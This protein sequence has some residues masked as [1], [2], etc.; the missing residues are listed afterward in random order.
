[1][2]NNFEI[3]KCNVVLKDEYI[4]DINTLS[5]QTNI[6]KIL[7]IDIQ[8]NKE[9]LKSVSENDFK[10]Y[11]KRY[12]E[13]NEF[14][15]IKNIT[16]DEILPYR[17]SNTYVYAII[18]LL[19][20]VFEN[21]DIVKKLEES[22]FINKI[23]IAIGFLIVYFF[24]NLGYAFLYGFYFG[25][26]TIDKI[27]F[28]QM[29]VNPVPFNFKS[30]VGI[31]LG[32]FVY[33]ILIGLPLMKILKSDNTK[34]RIVNTVIFIGI[35]L[36][37]V[38]CSAFLFIGTLDMDVIF[39]DMIYF[40]ITFIMLPITILIMLLFVKY[41]QKYTFT[42]LYGV[43]YTIMSAFI[44]S[45]YFGSKLNDYAKL[46]ILYAMY[47]M[48]VI[49]AKI[50][51]FVL[52]KIEKIQKYKVKICVKYGVIFMPIAVICALI[53][54]RLFGFELYSIKSVI[55]I[56]CSVTI[57]ILLIL[58]I[59]FLRKKINISWLK[60]R[61]KVINNN[62]SEI[63]NKKEIKYN[64]II[65]GALIL[66]AFIFAIIPNVT[67][68]T[69][70]MTRNTLRG[71]SKDK[72]IY[73]KADD[74]KEKQYVFGEI[75][76]Q[77]DNIYFVSKLPERK[78]M[79]IKNTNVFSVPCDK[80]WI[81]IN[82]DKFIELNNNFNNK[83]SYLSS[84]SKFKVLEDPKE[85]TLDRNSMDFHK[86]IYIQNSNDTNKDNYDFGIS[87]DVKYSMGKEKVDGF[88]LVFAY[89]FPSDIKNEDDKKLRK[90]MET[91][92][93]EY[94]NSI[95]QHFNIPEISVQ[96]PNYYYSNGIIKF[97]SKIDSEKNGRYEERYNFSS[98]E[99]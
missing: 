86:S 56:W 23:L 71:L 36:L 45:E 67:L 72:I 97:T 18:V 30:I 62:V 81:N 88:S 28:F 59:N 90:D 12:I 79:T 65:I 47:L 91:M 54:R 38:I 68:E 51:N 31:G 77:K 99:D 57:L 20:K 39:T 35:I 29:Y 11:V 70:K 13:K 84:D 40:I 19:N 48:P 10:K 17:Y 43:L 69:G 33:I 53:I 26:D 6:D 25:G 93:F 74:K 58:V 41:S 94:K 21:N 55:L 82:L 87:F 95:I 2:F 3:L 14:S 80:F 9:E 1:M 89:K 60:P 76:A 15:G 73:E 49:F 61:S 24:Y 27:S 37:L 52:S 78:L 46:F 22:K 66:G 64:Y 96:T 44:V 85:I 34:D 98:V 75:V 5:Q 32:L 50:L 7:I 92:F 16:F 83:Y 42:L 4:I 8:K 63:S